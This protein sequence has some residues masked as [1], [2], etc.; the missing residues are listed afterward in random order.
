MPSLLDLR[1]TVSALVAVAMSAALIAFAFII[2]DSAR[3]QMQTNARLSVGDA[4]V[5][6]QDGR[7]ANKTENA[8][9]DTL[10]SRVS[11]LND[12]ESARGTHWGMLWLDLPKQ[13][14]GTTGTHIVVQDV[15]T[16][17]RFTTLSSGRLPTASGEVAISTE[18]A[19]Q[20]VWASE[21][22]FSSEPPTT[23]TL[24]PSTRLPQWLALS[25]LGLTPGQ[26]GAAR[27]TQPPS[28]S[29]PWGPAPP[30]TS[31]ISPHGQEPTRMP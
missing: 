30:T 7:G 28:S 8:L 17:S 5:I 20:R 31:S 19:E 12:V 3:T 14:S 25:P 15:P 4:D 22:P 18:L 2:S 13:L 16:L 23:T 29:S 9:D 26:Q 1:R 27:C 21:T 10:L 6:V 24:T 11:A